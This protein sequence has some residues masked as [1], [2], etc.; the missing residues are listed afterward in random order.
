M[1]T[2]YKKLYEACGYDMDKG[3]RPYSSM[4]DEEVEECWDLMDWMEFIPKTES[5]K[6]RKR[7]SLM[8]EFENR[9]DA[10]EVFGWSSF[11]VKL[12]PYLLYKGFNVF[13]LKNN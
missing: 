4:T 7:Q 1:K 8:E 12:L 3:L 10:A 13:G 5:E 9:V 11:C 2:D 6:Y